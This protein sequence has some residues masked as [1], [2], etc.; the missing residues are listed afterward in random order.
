MRVDVFL[1]TARLIKRRT[2]AKELCEEGAIAVNGRTARAGRELDVGDELGLSLRNRRLLVS[3]VEIPERPP[4]A[5]AAS[6]LYRVLSD[7]RVDPEET[8]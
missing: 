1:K 5:A 3:V 2:L 4:S 8:D 6:R 7:I